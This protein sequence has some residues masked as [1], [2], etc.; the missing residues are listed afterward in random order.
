M[1]F[2]SQSSLLL[3]AVSA[4]ITDSVVY[5]HD[6]GYFSVN[7]FN[8]SVIESKIDLENGALQLMNSKSVVFL[9]NSLYGFENK[10]L[11]LHGYSSVKFANNDI[12]TNDIV[13]L[14]NI[15]FKHLVFIDNSFGCTD[16]SIKDKLFSI[17]LKDTG[18]NNYCY[19]D[20][21]LSLNKY[22]ELLRRDCVCNSEVTVE[23]SSMCTPCFL[24]EEITFKETDI[25]VNDNK[26]LGYIICASLF[27]LFIL[28]VSCCICHRDNVYKW[29]LLLLTDISPQQ[30]ESEHSDTPVVI[31]RKPQSDGSENTYEEIGIRSML[32]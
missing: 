6:S 26:M 12:F 1:R 14:L 15:K 8:F 19:T 11:L 22:K 30:L 16:C 2:K 27:L 17:D 7:V 3:E 32:K 25:A 10:S 20:C 21:K 5:I 18:D 13:N 23:F 31:Y 4:S 28:S 9:R 24:K 29:R